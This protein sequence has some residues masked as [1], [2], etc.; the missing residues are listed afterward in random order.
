[1]KIT[2]V[3]VT[4]NRLECLRIAL[5]KFEEQKLFPK[6]LVVVNNNST[7]GTT[8][9]LSDWEKVDAPFEKV[10]INSEVNRGGA[11]G[12][13]LGLS[14]AMKFNDTDWIWLSDDDAFI[15]E[16]TLY[17]LSKVYNASL[18]N[19]NVAALFTSVINKG[20][21]DLTHRRM[22]KKGIKGV[23]F[24]PITPD[25]YQKDYFK[26]TQGSYVGMLVKTEMIRKYGVT[27]EEFFIYYDDTEHSERLNLH[28][29]LY[30][31]PSSKITH[32]VDVATVSSWKDFYAARNSTIMIKEIYGSFY[33]FVHV[34]KRYLKS[35]DKS[36][37]KSIRRMEQTGLIEGIKGNIGLHDVYKPGWKPDN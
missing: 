18:K 28:G 20:S 25:V 37:S 21:Y 19:E 3:L 30:C 33:A 34:F 11:G 35:F 26:I 13:A 2:A 15:H 14:T 16:D 36:K 24:L 31:V 7:D 12:F 27:R 5:Q 8:E 10:V 4:F 29:N 22:V 23:Q 9:Y 32:D 1:M 6:R 17:E